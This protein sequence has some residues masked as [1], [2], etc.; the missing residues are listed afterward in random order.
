MQRAIH[1]IVMI[2]K[3]CGLRTVAHAQAAASAGA[4]LIGLVFAP[5]RRQI[6]PTE[7]A[8]IVHALRARPGPHPL[9]VGLFVNTAPAMINTISTQV[10]LD[11]VQLSGDEPPTYAEA[12]QR[13]VI[14]AIRMDNTPA[15]AAW[16]VLVQGSSAD[17]TAHMSI[18]PRLMVDAHVPGAYG[19]TGVAADWMRAAQLAAQVPLILAGGLTPANIATAIAQVR[20]WGVDVSSGVEIAGAKDPQQIEAFI[21]AARAA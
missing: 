14:K 21:A 12:V 7:G 1:N 11:L 13:P 17:H 6:S 16:V 15:E 8:T 9:V 19:G 18:G 3:I 5:S 20:P 2:I 10:G 4:D